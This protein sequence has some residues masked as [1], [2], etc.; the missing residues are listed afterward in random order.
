MKKSEIISWLSTLLILIGSGNLSAQKEN[1]ENIIKKDNGRI[2][3]AY[4]AFEDFLNSADRSWGNY[5]KTVLEAYPEM[6]AV[7]NKTL[8]WGAI[9]SIEFPKEVANYK[10]GDWENYFRSV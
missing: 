8:S 7:H 2:I 6:Q 9:D 10:P 4:K 1:Q 5:K 3:L